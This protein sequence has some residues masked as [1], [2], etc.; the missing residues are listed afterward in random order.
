MSM[1]DRYCLAPLT[2]QRRLEISAAVP[3]SGLQVALEG[4]AG[5]VS[6]PAISA[7]GKRKLKMRLFLFFL[8]KLIALR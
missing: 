8:I 4:D 1:K 6:A 2:K 3:R 7:S 5:R